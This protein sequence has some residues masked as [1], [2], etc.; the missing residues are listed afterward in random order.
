MKTI[1]LLA[2]FGLSL[3]AVHQ[4]SLVWRE[5]KKVQMIRNGEYKAYLEYLNHLR[6]ASP[7]EFASLPQNVNDFG[8]YEYLGNITVGTP[9]Q[10]FVVVL[11]TGSANLWVPGPS[12]RTYCS[13]KNKYQ[14][15]QSSTY[16]KNGQSWSIQYGSGSAKGILAQD[17]VRFG[18]VGQSQLAVP[19]TT[20]GVA[21]QIS[22]DFNNDAADGILGLA[23]TSLAVDGVVPPLINAINQG[24]LD[25]PLFTVWLEHRGMLNNVGGGVFTYGAVDTTNCG[26]VIGYQPLSSATYYQFKVAGFAL[27]SYSSNSAVDVISDTGTSFLGGPQ[28]VVDGLA[29]AAGA[30]YDSSY[31]L[32]FIDCDATPGSLDITIGSTKYS[33]QPVN[34]IVK[35]D[36]NLCVFGAFAFDF[37]GYGPS[38]ILGDPFIRQYCNIYD[39]GNQRMGFAPSLQK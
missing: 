1:I 2:L 31:E 36:E 11:D 38:W 7:S 25:Q 24:L 15:G 12:C 29:T 14:S 9:D 23:F 10:K 16:V 8:D 19:T 33:I 28:T 26:S 39:I 32:Y 20:F 21:S 27:G 3:A 4:H 34:Y 22:S 13:A 18:D 6:A 5:S 35:V 17:T 30:T 37:G